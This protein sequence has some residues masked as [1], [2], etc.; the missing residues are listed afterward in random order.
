M[1][2][3]DDATFD[4]LRKAVRMARDHQVVSVAVLRRKLLEENPGEA[5]VIDRALVAW[6]EHE[7]EQA[8]G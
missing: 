3:L 4:M 5:E 1:T 2:Q 6:A 8:A 7:V